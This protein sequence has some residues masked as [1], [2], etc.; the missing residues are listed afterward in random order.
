MAF[1]IVDTIPVPVIKKFSDEVDQMLF[2]FKE[3]K[4]TSILIQKLS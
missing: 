3:A 4:E 2:Y 1:P